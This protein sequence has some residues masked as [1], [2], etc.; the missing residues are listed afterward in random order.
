MNKEQSRTK[1]KL[2]LSRKLSGLTYG[3][4]SHF[5]HCLGAPKVLELGFGMIKIFRIWH[6]ATKAL[7][8]YFFIFRSETLVCHNVS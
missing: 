6:I 7:T 5:I 8:D 3:K 2:P 4:K 1:Y